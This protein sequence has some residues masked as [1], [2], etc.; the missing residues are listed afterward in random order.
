MGNYYTHQARH[1]PKVYRPQIFRLAEKEDLARFEKLMNQQGSPAAVDEIDIQVAELI[2]CL[3]PRKSFSETRIKQEVARILGEQPEFYGVWVW[4]PWLGNVVHLLDHQNFMT[5]RTNRNRYKITL[6]EQTDLSKLKI[7]IAGLSVGSAVATTL[8][9]ESSVGEL[10]IADFDLIELSNLNRIMSGVQSIGIPKT[11]SLARRIAEI[12]PFLPVKCYHEGVTR[13]NMQD[14]LLG[15]GKLDFLVDE[16]DSLDIKVLLRHHARDNGIPVVMHTSDRGMLDIERF[17]LEP[18]RLPFH[19]LVGE[20]D[21]DQLSGLTTEEKIPYILPMIGAEKI[22]GRLKASLMEVDRTIFT[23]PQLAADV[24]NGGGIVTEAIR[25]ISLGHHNESGRYY[26]DTRSLIKPKENRRPATSPMNEENSIPELTVERMREIV[27]RFQVADGPSLD[28]EVATALVEAAV[29]APS[30]GN[31]QPWKWFVTNRA[32]FLFHDPQRSGFSDVLKMGSLIAQG[33]ASELLMLRSCQMG[34]N[35]ERILFPIEEEELLVAA[36]VFK[37]SAD[38]D[39]EFYFVSYLADHI[40]ER[41]TNRAV[42]GVVPVS[43]E[44]VRFLTKI[45]RTV[46]GAELKVIDDSGPLRELGNI[47]SGCDRIRFTTKLLHSE[48]YQKEVRWTDEMAKQSGDG[49]DLGTVPL[50][51]SEKAG[52]QLAGDWEAVSL[53][54]DWNLGEVF[55]EFAMKCMKNT[56]AMGLI[57][58]GVLNRESIFTGGT[59]IARISLAA[60]MRGISIHPMMSPLMLFPHV[61]L[62]GGE[63]F[64]DHA[65]E[66]LM[67][68]YNEFRLVF[69]DSEG[70]AEVYLFRLFKAARIAKKAYR[71]NLNNVLHLETSKPERERAAR[72]NTGVPGDP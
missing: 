69:P 46:Q 68:Y 30:A 8:A 21:P 54:G 60:E 66:S 58:V 64:S 52:F 12:D 53:L 2:K 1:W 38:R 63:G 13:E 37:G 20:L 31:N 45:C 41:M 35:F 50:N 34:L 10:R 16:C 70:A 47:I 65:C 43:N 11:V 56:P 40:E 22:S 32:I 51:A 9:L 14:F 62:Q 15:N 25:M 33:A 49:L 39:N 28:F 3:D 48:F 6:Q 5:V 29:R 27:S 42:E 17:D 71:R 23:W 19:G 36:M 18:G 24:L 4:Y 7:G 61:M 59:A 57:S 26:V 44:D 72:A 67:N 55:G